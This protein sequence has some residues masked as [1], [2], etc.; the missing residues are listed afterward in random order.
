MGHTLR[1]SDDAMEKQAI[2][3]NPQRTRKRGRRKT[4]WKRTVCDETGHD[5]KT[6]GEV[7][8]LASNRVRRKTFTETLCSSVE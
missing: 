8:A 3:W 4:T 7:T 2:D 1:K 6:W 5:G